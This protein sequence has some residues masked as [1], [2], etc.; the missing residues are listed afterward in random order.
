M[1]NSSSSHLVEIIK[2]KT[3]TDGEIELES[4]QHLRRRERQVI[5]Y[6]QESLNW[7]LHSKEIPPLFLPHHGDLVEF[8]IVSPDAASTRVTNRYGK[9]RNSHRAKR[10]AH[11]KVVKSC[12]DTIDKAMEN[13]LPHLERE[14]GSVVKIYNDQSGYLQ[15]CDRNEHLFFQQRKPEVGED[16]AARVPLR[17]GD[18]VEFKFVDQQDVHHVLPDFKMPKFSRGYY[19]CEVTPIPKGIYI[20]GDVYI[21]SSRINMYMYHYS[22]YDFHT[23]DGRKEHSWTHI[24]CDGY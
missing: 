15:C 5:E 8:E 21:V 9:N 11:L 24:A 6:N 17:V 19:A 20:V 13:F 12:F 4:E 2:S 7:S 10:A 3:F 18:E 14:M 1:S 23:R 16:L 22:R